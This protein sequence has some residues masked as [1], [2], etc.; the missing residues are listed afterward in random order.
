[1]EV[2]FGQIRTFKTLGKMLGTKGFG[3][4]KKLLQNFLWQYIKLLVF[5]K[6]LIIIPVTINTLIS[7]GLEKN[8]IDVFSSP[9]EL[10]D[11]VKF[12]LARPLCREKMV[13]RA[14]E[15]CTP[16]YSYSARARKIID[17]I[18]SGCVTETI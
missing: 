17:I 13:R 11:K 4:W 5:K 15:R 10:A 14:L 12:Y 18:L 1:M 16:D 6:A 9:E 2:F 8:E 3:T 7:I